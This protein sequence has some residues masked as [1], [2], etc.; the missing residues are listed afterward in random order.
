MIVSKKKEA[1]RPYS[2]SPNLSR[3]RRR[4]QISASD[5]RVVRPAKERSPSWKVGI[6]ASRGHRL[7]VLQA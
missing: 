4:S 6:S 2:S 7:F 3:Q 5:A 1:E